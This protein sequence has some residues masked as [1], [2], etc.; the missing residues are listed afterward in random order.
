[1]GL[2]W[3]KKH[4]DDDGKWDA[5][6]RRYVDFKMGTVLLCGGLVGSAERKHEI[7]VDMG[8]RDDVGGDDLAHLLAPA[9]TGVDGVTLDVGTVDTAP[10]FAIDGQTKMDR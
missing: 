4:Q 9:D 1:M 8:T 2:E 3:L 7:D 10:A 5:D 6:D